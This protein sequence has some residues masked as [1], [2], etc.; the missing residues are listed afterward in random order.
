MM[1]RLV[2]FLIRR[3]LG[4]KLYQTF[5]FKNQRSEDDF[6]FFSPTEIWKHEGAVVKHSSVSLNWLLSDECEIEKGV[7]NGFN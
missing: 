7:E 6:Y 4:L 1:K 2:I 5:Q 3:K